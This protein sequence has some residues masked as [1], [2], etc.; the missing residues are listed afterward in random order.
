[1]LRVGA[2]VQEE[3]DYYSFVIHGELKLSL[4]KGWNVVVMHG[5]AVVVLSA[6]RLSC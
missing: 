2:T 5:V 4:H 3:S 6:A 1:M